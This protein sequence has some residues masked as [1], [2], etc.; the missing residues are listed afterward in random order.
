L[1]DSGKTDLRPYSAFKAHRPGMSVSGKGR[2]RRE[3]LR[4]EKAGGKNA[5][6]L[7]P[8]LIN[9]SLHNNECRETTSQAGWPHS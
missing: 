4:A 8:Y 9:A 6:R 7:V 5:A 3:N 2:D 1:N